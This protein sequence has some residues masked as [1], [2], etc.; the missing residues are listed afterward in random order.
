MNNHHK[1]HH[2]RSESTL[3][4]Q[5]SLGII[6]SL[7]QK[8]RSDQLKLQ[9]IFSSRLKQKHR[10]TR[11]ETPIPFPKN[12]HEYAQQTN[13]KLHGSDD[14]ERS[15]NTVLHEPVVSAPCQAEGE[16]VLEDEQACE[17]FDGNVAYKTASVCKFAFSGIGEVRR[18][19]MSIHD[20]QRTR[21]SPK[22]HTHDLQ[23]KEEI[24][25]K[26]AISRSV[27][28]RNAESI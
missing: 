11:P 27:I 22:N 15:F 9:F 16:D 7:E 8:L 14:V 19:T 6:Q 2:A 18:L 20:V 1:T 13:H 25:P 10:M 5:G 3:R 12:I 26:P 28:T 21:Y 24:R 4:K 17:C 23:C